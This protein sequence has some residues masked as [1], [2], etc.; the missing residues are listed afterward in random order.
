MGNFRKK[1][2][3]RRLLNKKLRKG[4]SSAFYYLG[5]VFDCKKSL[6]KLLPTKN[7][8]QNLKVSGP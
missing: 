3:Q 6:Y 4:R 5:P 1:P 7:V 8:V 2:S